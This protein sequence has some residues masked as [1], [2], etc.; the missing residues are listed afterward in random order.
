MKLLLDEM[1][2]AA[3]AEQLRHRGHDVIAVSEHPELRG[4][5]DPEL[6]AHCGRE[7]RAVLD[8]QRTRE[9]AL[10]RYSAFSDSH[11]RKY[12]WLLNVQH[13]IGRL[14]PSRSITWLARAMENERF[15]AWGFDHYLAIA[16]P[17]TSASP[18]AN[19]RMP[20]SMAGSAR[21]A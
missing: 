6:L 1:L 5:P 12:R 13:T 19:R 17:P 21:L 2:P 20:S 15:C 9:Q 14:T 10:A 16:P 11:E 18:R 4:L 3:I 7:L 8:G